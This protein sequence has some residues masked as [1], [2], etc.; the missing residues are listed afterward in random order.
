MKPQTA[1]PSK[2]KTMIDM[3]LLRRSRHSG[4]ALHSSTL[5]LR[6]RPVGALAYTSPRPHRSIP[7]GY[8]STRRCRAAAVQI[9]PAACV[10]GD[11]RAGPLLA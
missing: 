9:L 6:N 5:A 11:S 8:C 1:S 3:R 2:M 10:I 4:N 7:R